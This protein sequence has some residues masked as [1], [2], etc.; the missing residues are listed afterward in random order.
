VNSEKAR[1]AIRTA[2]AAG[3]TLVTAVAFVIVWTRSGISEETRR[4]AS[5]GLTL[6]FVVLWHE[7]LRSWELV[8]TGRRQSR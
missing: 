7:V 6:V 8:R 2:A 3:L 5:F 1:W 4:A